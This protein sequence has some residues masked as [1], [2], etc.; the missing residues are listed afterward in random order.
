MRCGDSTTGN[1]K[2]PKMDKHIINDFE[3]PSARQI[4]VLSADLIPFISEPQTSMLLVRVND[5]KSVQEENA[6]FE[7]EVGILTAEVQQVLFS[8]DFENGATISIPFKRIVDPLIRARNGINQW[9]N[10]PLTK[11][12]LLMVA[13][14]TDNPN[15][16]KAQAG[17]NVESTDDPEIAA[18]RECYKIEQDKDIIEKPLLLQKAL[19]GREDIL[20]YYTLDYLGRRNMLGRKTGAE[21]ISNAIV[22]ENTAPN[23]KID[24]GFYL[25]ESYFFD[26]DLGADSTN[27]IVVTTLAMILVQETDVEIL[28]NAAQLLAS[29]V[30]GEFSPK[31]DTNLLIMSS[32]ISAIHNPTPKQVTNVLYK[33]LPKVDEM[34]KERIRELLEAW[35]ISK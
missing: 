2:D 33:L 19:T 14:V 15:M 29:C 6:D 31:K 30:L 4:E 18:V 26:S 27:Q 12:S 23:Q 16:M 32:L 22:A 5:I 9:N 35:Q 13:V 11:G 17:I 25:T 8:K 20:R 10:L 28:S 21:I 3:I 1:K 24:I 34:E 7:M